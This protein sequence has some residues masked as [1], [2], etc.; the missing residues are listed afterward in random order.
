MEERNHNMR[1][2]NDHPLSWLDS[3][4]VK[5]YEQLPLSDDRATMRIVILTEDVLV[6][7][8]QHILATVIVGGSAPQHGAKT[9]V[10]E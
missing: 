1:G 6:E 2:R 7:Y 4:L 3:Q 5:R 10:R 9:A 8:G